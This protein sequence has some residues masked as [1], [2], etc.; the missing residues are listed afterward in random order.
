MIGPS[1]AI[2]R[3][4]LRV[5][6]RSRGP[7]LV[8]ALLAAAS[9][10]LTFGAVFGR[11]MVAA[12]PVAFS[13][14]LF[15][16]LVRLVPFAAA[17][18]S[19]SSFARARRD[20]RLESVLSA[21]VSEAEIVRGAFAACFVR[22]AVQLFLAGSCTVLVCRACGVSAL[23]GAP[24]L[25]S[26]A[27]GV[28]SFTAMCAAFGVFCSLATGSESAAAAVVVMAGSSLSS[29][30]LGDLPGFPPPPY[31]EIFAPAA[32][33]AGF[34]DSRLLVTCLGAA[35]LAVFLSVRFLESRR[36]LASSAR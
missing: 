10:A 12:T 32:F 31:D 34:I 26:G 14:G 17:F 7:W 30:A 29:L 3:R 2:C 13:T 1:A 20:G 33:A 16:A 5:A 15:E 24:L 4:S 21:P 23:P 11:D 36:W 25:A 27:L 8:A 9:G 19:A 18:S 6:F 22:A 28:L 35:A